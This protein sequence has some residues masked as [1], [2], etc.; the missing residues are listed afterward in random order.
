M[1][2]E[3]PL[4]TPVQVCKLLSVSPATLCRWRQSGVGP[5][6]LA[7]TPSTPRYRMGD[8]VAWLDSRAS[9]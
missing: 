2:S 1:G 9:R 8:V 7:L 6:W 3:D 5:T 4:L